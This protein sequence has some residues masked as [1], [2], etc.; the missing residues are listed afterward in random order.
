MVNPASRRVHGG[1]DEDDG[2]GLLPSEGP[3]PDNMGDLHL[4]DPRGNLVVADPMREIEFP[5]PKGQIKGVAASK[6]DG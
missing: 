5:H 3:L 4:P 6:N 2:G 1:A